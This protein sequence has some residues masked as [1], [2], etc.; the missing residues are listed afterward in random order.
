MKHLIYIFLALFLM[1]CSTENV[2][3]PKKPIIFYASN[4]VTDWDVSYGNEERQKMDIHLRGQHYVDQ[5]NHNV[6]MTGEQPPTII[7]G[8]GS[9]WYFSD[10]RKHEHMISPYLQMGYNVV[11]LNYSIKQGVA[12]ATKDVRLALLHLMRNNSEYGLDLDN[13]FL[14]GMSAGAHMASFLG[15][16]QNS[17][18][19]E[20]AFSDS[21]N[22]RGVINIMGGG[23]ECSDIYHVLKSHENQ[24]WRNVGKSLVDDH[25]KADSIL[26]AWCPS[27]YLDQGDPPMFIGI[28]EKD[29]FG[30]PEKLEALTSIL[31]EHNIPH[32]LASYP[33]SGHGFL[34]E[35]Y[36]DMFQRIVLFIDRFKKRAREK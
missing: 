34:T 36:N 13:V 10:K 16:A 21:L 26:E 14:A 27:S 28:G 11:N 12:K 23:A 33:N 7:F 20:I 4:Y 15:A 22:I 1:A 6:R 9:A 29:Q 31:V 19:S 17:G 2:I 32:V 30:S 35:D 24:W 18:I 3:P 8:H 5:N 25:A